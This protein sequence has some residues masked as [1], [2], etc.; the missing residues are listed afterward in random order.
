MQ[1]AT[2]RKRAEIVGRMTRYEIGLSVDGRQVDTLAYT[3]RPTRG[4]L[5][6]VAQ[7]HGKRIV[8]LSG[9]NDDRPF[10]VFTKQKITLGRASIYFT[11]RT[12]RGADSA[13]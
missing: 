9:V 6:K 2:P 1:S 3:T 7:A 10:E 11:G 4:S 5:V 12:E 8:A 13:S